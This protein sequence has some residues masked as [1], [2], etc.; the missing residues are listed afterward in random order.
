M[1]TRKVSLWDGGESTGAVISRQPSTIGPDVKAGVTLRK[2]PDCSLGLPLVS[3][4]GDGRD[5]QQRNV[6]NPDR[7]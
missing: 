3:A 1:A 4:V 6:R 5:Q 7:G 2:A